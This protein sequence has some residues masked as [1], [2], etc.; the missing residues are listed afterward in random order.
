MLSVVA[1]AIMKNVIWLTYN[2]FYFS[3]LSIIFLSV[4]I[5]SLY[6][7]C[8][9]AERYY[10]ESHFSKCRYAELYRNMCY[11]AVLLC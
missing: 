10:R 5:L 9:C 4:I 7:E 6:A 8:H 1:L 2:T 11:Y 3:M